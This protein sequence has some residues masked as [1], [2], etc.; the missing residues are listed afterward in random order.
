[1]TRLKAEDREDLVAL[2]AHVQD[3]AVRVGDMTFLPGT[4]RF[5][6]LV[7]RFRWEA[8]GAN[9]RV[10]AALRIEGA[11]AARSRGFT[12]ED[13]DLVLN[14]LDIGAYEG[15]TGVDLILTFSE[16]RSLQVSADAIDLLLED[17]G[18][19]YPA[20]ARPRHPG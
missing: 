17:V 14:L 5:V 7:R 16:G 19:A 11:R 2:S 18:E 15:A 3:A 9:E 8:S 6:A 13:R 10:A 12:A 20:R 1:M 4:R